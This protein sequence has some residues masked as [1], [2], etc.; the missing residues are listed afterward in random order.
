[1]EKC[2]LPSD[3]ETL[4]EQA[5][6]ICQVCDGSGKPRGSGGKPYDVAVGV[7]QKEN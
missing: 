3:N 6:G 5:E 7:G 1:V 2:G 4:R